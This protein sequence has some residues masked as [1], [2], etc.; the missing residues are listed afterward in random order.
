MSDDTAA[1]PGY[2]P[3][4]DRPTP[5][6]GQVKA[7]ELKRANRRARIQW[8]IVVVAILIASGLLLLIGG[9]GVITR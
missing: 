3:P 8:A 5:R 7:E 1:D 9:D 2:T 4:K 6:R